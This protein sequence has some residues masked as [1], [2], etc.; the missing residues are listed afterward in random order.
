MLGNKSKIIQLVIKGADMR[1]SMDWC[2]RG[3]SL[4]FMWNPVVLHSP[5]PI[6]IKMIFTGFVLFCLPRLNLDLICS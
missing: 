2:V 3:K 5:K 6:L 4:L 1:N